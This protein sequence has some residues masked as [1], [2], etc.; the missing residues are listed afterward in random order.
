MPQEHNP[1]LGERIRDEKF[2]WHNYQW[3]EM[4]TGETLY[5]ETDEE[6]DEDYLDCHLLHSTA[7]IDNPDYY[8]VPENLLTAS[9]MYPHTQGTVPH[10]SP[11]SV[12]EAEMGMLYGA[13][14]QGAKNTLHNE[15]VRSHLRNSLASSSPGM[16]LGSVQEDEEHLSPQHY[17]MLMEDPLDMYTASL[18]DTS[19]DVDG[20]LYRG[21][22]HDDLGMSSSLY[23]SGEHPSFRRASRGHHF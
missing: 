6:E 8:N 9:S 5:E 21:S 1:A 3:I 13:G 23:A 10:S 18:G 4:M 16:L 20:Q 15:F 17:S 22:L 11:Y 19:A 2:R 7:D 14:L 12:A